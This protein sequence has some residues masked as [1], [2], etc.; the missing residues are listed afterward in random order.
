MLS[1]VTSSDMTQ[2]FT[3]RRKGRRLC[4]CRWLPMHT[5]PVG[6]IRKP[7][8]FLSATTFDHSLN[9]P[10]YAIWTVYQANILLEGFQSAGSLQSP[11]HI[12]RLDAGML[13]LGLLEV[14]RRRQR[15][16][17]H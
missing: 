7:V 10:Q 9:K 16:T 11:L 13:R 12:A 1:G 14:P 6:L 8:H 2:P 17:S 5:I 4:N 3:E 15:Q